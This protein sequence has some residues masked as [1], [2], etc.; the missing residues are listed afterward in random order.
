M[1]TLTK[2]ATVIFGY[3]TGNPTITLL[4][5]NAVSQIIGI[6]YFGENTDKF[7][8]CITP[9]QTSNFLQLNVPSY[10]VYDFISGIWQAKDWQTTSTQIFSDGTKKKVGVY[11]VYAKGDCSGGGSTSNIFEFII[12]R[13]EATFV[14]DNGTTCTIQLNNQSDSKF[15]IGVTAVKTLYVEVNGVWQSLATANIGAG[16]RG[17]NVALTYN[18]TIPSTK[19]NTPIHFKADIVSSDNHVSYLD[20]WLECRYSAVVPQ[21][22]QPINKDLALY[23]K[24]FCNIVSDKCVG[25]FS[26][27]EDKQEIAD[28]QLLKII[29]TNQTFFDSL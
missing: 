21:P 8:Y 24:Q 6:G 15:A 12:P 10:N 4:P 2:K 7:L 16:V 5:C 1:W 13:M 28:A 23:A 18:Y 3:G 27:L 29:S 14:S 26:G 9:L 19:S 20:M 25:R 22:T 11:S 17:G